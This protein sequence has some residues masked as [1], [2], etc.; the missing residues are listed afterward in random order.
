MDDYIHYSGINKDNILSMLNID[1]LYKYCFNHIVIKNSNLEHIDFS[2]CSFTNTFFENCIVG[3]TLFNKCSFSNVVI[4]KINNKSTV[5]FNN[6]N[7]ANFILDKIDGDISIKDATLINSELLNINSNDIIDFTTTFFV[8][9]KFNNCKMRSLLMS[10]ALLDNVIIEDCIIEG[11]FDNSIINNLIFMK[12]SI[13]TSTAVKMNGQNLKLD[14]TVISGSNLSEINVNNIYMSNSLITN[15]FLI[16]AKLQNG[17]IDKTNIT[18]CDLTNVNFKDTKFIGFPLKNNILNNT[19]FIGTKY[20]GILI[21]YP[22]EPGHKEHNYIFEK[23]LGEGT[24]GEVWKVSNNGKYYAIK[25]YKSSFTISIEDEISALTKITPICNEYA[26]CYYG[27]YVAID[28]KTNDLH[29]RVILEF[30]DGPTLT[31]YYELNNLNDRLKDDRCLINLIYGLD[32][33]FASGVTHQDIKEDNIIYDTNS[34]K[35]RYIDWG[36]GCLKTSCDPD[37]QQP[38]GSSGTAYTKPP[39]LKWGYNNQITFDEGMAHDIWSIGVVLYHWYSINGPLF[40][41]VQKYRYFYELT[42]DEIINRINRIPTDDYIKDIL[43]KLLTI[44][45]KIRLSN[46]IEVLNSIKDIV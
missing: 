17:I 37:C 45:V 39:E 46:W 34:L 15:T 8:G 22:I 12:C 18:N 23:K 26:V 41:Y 30:I 19:N 16:N 44:D 38:C 25:I 33:I 21:N 4:G 6:S 5:S 7:F 28:V 1:S 24:Y 42:Q 31:K 35:F 43:I 11:T 2:G 14:R 27:Y 32:A 10:N 3:N 9:S 13:D 29:T 40:D 20:Y 36:L